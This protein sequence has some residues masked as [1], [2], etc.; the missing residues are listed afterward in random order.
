MMQTEE[1]DNG[2]RRSIP[3]E[4]SEFTMGCDQVIM[5]IGLGPN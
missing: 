1:D 2:R 3:I 5:A 4:G